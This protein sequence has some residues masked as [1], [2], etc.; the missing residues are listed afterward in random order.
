MKMPHA[1]K[2]LWLEHKQVIG[3]TKDESFIPIV[4]LQHE[5]HYP[6]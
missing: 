3:F 6:V 1:V 5:Q 4:A 2:Q